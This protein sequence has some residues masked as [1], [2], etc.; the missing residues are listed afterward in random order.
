MHLPEVFSTQQLN[1]FFGHLTVEDYKVFWIRTPDYNQQ[2]YLSPA[3]ETVWGFSCRQLYEHPTHWNDHLIGEN[4]PEFVDL[5]KARV[6]SED[7]NP[8][9]NTVL[10]RIRNANDRL[11]WIKDSHFFLLN[12]NN[13]LVAV[14]GIA[15]AISE[16]QWCIE[17][18]HCCNPALSQV[19][20]E[21]DLL[22]ILKTELNLSTSQADHA[23]LLNHD[24]DALPYIT[25][26]SG[27]R[28][29][30]SKR[31]IECLHHLIK[32]KAAKEIARQMDISPRTVELHISHIKNKMKCKTSL[33][34]VS[35]IRGFAL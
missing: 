24:K 17:L 11:V 35:H 13:Q 25:T 31:E 28:I 10:Y 27:S 3:F 20:Y 2:I 29:L 19:H 23:V 22:R 6:K 14:A 4:V 34:L 18:K 16:T 30:L 32:G 7:N 12:K 15:Q 21:E 33:E 1:K 26:K 8:K 5:L 9:N